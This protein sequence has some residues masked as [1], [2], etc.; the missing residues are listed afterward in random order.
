MCLL[1]LYWRRGCFTAYILFLFF[2]FWVVSCGWSNTLYTA[3]IAP[4]DARFCAFWDQAVL[5]SLQTVSTIYF[6][7][8]DQWSTVL[9]ICQK[10]IA[11]SPAS[12]HCIRIGTTGDGVIKKGWWQHLIHFLLLSHC[13]SALFVIQV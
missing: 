5:S 4:Y 1:F 10:Y 8:T 7:V 11:F 2:H 13:W 9:L 12:I 3:C 6:I